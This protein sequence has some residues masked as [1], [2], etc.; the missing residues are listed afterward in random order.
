MPPSSRP[1]P[2]QESPARAPP[3]LSVVEGTVSVAKVGRIERDILAYE[4]FVENGLV[5]AWALRLYRAVCPY[6]LPVDERRF[7][8]RLALA[9]LRAEPGALDALR[10]LVGAD[11][12]VCP[13]LVSIG[14]IDG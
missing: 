6:G 9:R 14:V 3:K 10:V 12:P 4:G 2:P 8:F 11:L 1:S 7:V 13:Y 5:V